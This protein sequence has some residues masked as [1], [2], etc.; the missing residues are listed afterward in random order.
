MSKCHFWLWTVSCHGCN[1]YNFKCL[2][3]NANLNKSLNSLFEALTAVLMKT[4]CYLDVTPCM[5]TNHPVINCQSTRRHS[6]SS[7]NFETFLSSTFCPLHS[8]K[9]VHLLR[10]SVPYLKLSD[11]RAQK[12][13]LIKSCPTGPKVMTCH[14]VYISSRHPYG[15]GQNCTMSS[16]TTAAV[17]CPR[18]ALGA[19]RYGDC[20]S[21]LSGLN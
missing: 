15:C 4:R 21:L 11:E 5:L 14:G 6:P 17:P 3:G 20:P 18:D 7:Q 19:F 9:A 8:R 16:Q 10:R 1:V 2:E 12:L 13:N